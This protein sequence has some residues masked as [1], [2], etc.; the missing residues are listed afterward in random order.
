MDLRNA[1]E[2]DISFEISSLSRAGRG[3]QVVTFITFLALPDQRLVVGDTNSEEYTND[4][5]VITHV[6]V[7]CCF[8]GRNKLYDFLYFFTCVLG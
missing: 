2:V 5:E 6:W 7:P 4:C 3:H 8:R 1:F